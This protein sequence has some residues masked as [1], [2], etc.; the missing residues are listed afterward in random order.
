MKDAT[1][2]IELELKREELFLKYIS[3]ARAFIVDTSPASR[4]RLMKSLVDL[5]GKPHLISGFKNFQETEARIAEMPPIIIS[6]YRLQDKSGFD[7]LQTFRKYQGNERALFILVTA[8]SSQSLVAQ[9]AE[10]DIDAF[11]LKPYT[12][13]SLKQVLMT[14]VLEKFFPSPYAVQVDEGKKLLFSGKPAAAKEH[15]SAAMKLHPKPAL[16]CFYYGQAELM[17]NSLEGAEKKYHEGLEFNK[18]HYKCLTYLFDLLFNLKRYDEAYEVVKQIATY[19]PANP[20]RLGTVL[21]LAIMTDNFKDIETYYE[22]F[23]SL[24]ERTDELIRYICSAMITCGRYYLMH[25]YPERA[26]ILFEKV[27]TT[28][29][30]FEKYLFYIVQNLIEFSLHDEIP[31]FMSRFSKESAKTRE[32]KISL[33][34]AQTCKLAPRE[35]IILSL[36]MLKDKN[37]SYGVYFVYIRALIAMDR[38]PEAKVA[39]EEGM[40]LYPDKESLFKK[41]FEQKTKN[42]AEETA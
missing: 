39:M 31:S 5:G 9:A 22:L 16:A 32:F 28:S 6:E 38:E 1:K 18:I 17:E 4:N 3:Q 42:Q 35:V 21:R 7:L 24:E 40:F 14:A 30:N 12:Q 11:L 29:A 34:L 10:E 13:D 26:L 27:K 15:F 23:T 19:F 41:L 2:Q 25:N 20:K 8:N 33:F 36:K 37:I